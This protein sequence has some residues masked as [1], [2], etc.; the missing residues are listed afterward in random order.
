MPHF[1]GWLPIPALD[2]VAYTSSWEKPVTV[3]TNPHRRLDKQEDANIQSWALLN[4][5]S[6]IPTLTISHLWVV[7]A[8]RDLLAWQGFLGHHFCSGASGYLNW[9]L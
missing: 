1:R 4:Y 5:T 9:S 6:A 8:L 3:N 7:T 2:I